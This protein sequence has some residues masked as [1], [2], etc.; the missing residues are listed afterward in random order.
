VES[1]PKEWNIF[2]FKLQEL[3]FADAAKR[4]R[5]RAKQRSAARVEQAKIDRDMK[6]SVNQSK[7][8]LTPAE[9]TP[10]IDMF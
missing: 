6:N 8:I 9:D 4:A 5:A 10:E 1:K 2:G 3:S 7:A